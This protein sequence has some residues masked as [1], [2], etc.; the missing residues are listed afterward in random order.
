MDFIDLEKVHET[1]NELIRRIVFLLKDLISWSG[2]R[3]LD[4]SISKSAI[5]VL[6]GT[7]NSTQRN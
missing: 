2:E 7:T 1:R 4:F 6:K 5:I 3:G